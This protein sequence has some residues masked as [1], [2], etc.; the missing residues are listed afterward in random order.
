MIC[1]L[2]WV[3][4]YCCVC[5]TDILGQSEA[6]FEAAVYSELADVLYILN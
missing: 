3:T 4:G 5:K 6:I 1:L 2:L